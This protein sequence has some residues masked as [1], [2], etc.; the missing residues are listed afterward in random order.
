M[1]VLTDFKVVSSVARDGTPINHIC[2]PH[3]NAQRWLAYCGA[4]FLYIYDQ[5]ADEFLADP[6]QVARTCPACTN[7]MNEAGLSLTRSIPGWIAE[8]RGLPSQR[9]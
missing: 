8:P 7:V 4:E 9:N 3:K 5:D 2:Q 1:R 6:I